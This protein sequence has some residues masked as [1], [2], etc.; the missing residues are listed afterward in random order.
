MTVE[1]IGIIT[2]L[3]G[4]I[5]LFL[6]P[7]V[8]VYIFVGSTLLGAAAAF[9]LDS[10]GG[11][12]IQPAHLLL[13]FLAFKL[14]SVRDIARSFVE[15]LFPGHAGFW[16]ALAAA[17]GTVTAYA[18][19][20]IFFAQTFVFPV[21]VQST[22]SYSTA[23]VPSTSNFTQSVYFIGNF[24]CFAL[25]Y[26]FAMFPKYRRHLARAVVLCVALNL[27]FAVADFVTYSTGTTEL[28]SI[29]RNSTY[30]LLSESEMAGFK[31]IVGSFVETSSFAYWTMG[32]FAFA[33][34]LWLYGVSPKVTSLLTIGSFIALL[35]STSTTA[36]ASLVPFGALVYCAVAIRAL[37]MPVTRQMM[38]LLTIVPIV[39]ILAVLCIA[40]N[41]DAAHYTMD[42]LDSMILNKMSTGSGMERSG[43]NSQA[44]QNFWDTFG[45]GVG[46]GS[47]RSSSFLIAALS[48]LGLIGTGIYAVFMFHIWFGQRTK[49]V[50]GSFDD[51]I[52]PAARAACLAQLIAG[53]V[54]GGL[55]DLGLPFFIFAALACIPYPAADATRPAPQAPIAFGRKPAE[56]RSTT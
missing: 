55:V 9:V 48:N 21:R 27:L 53:S 32:Y 12:T 23:L 47:A 39:F 8:L 28:M 3:A 24:A 25:L 22:G 51:A 13:G 7:Y 35:M 34:T 37:V 41:D 31:R 11:T 18:L 5:S 40:L 19:P 44:M 14:L 29:I 52:V 1:P 38:A 20:R 42:L 36:Y 33:S 2:L 45:F 4:I 10:L 16:L 6:P 15:S 46:N 49:F 56:L 30:S 26:G 17:Y 54:S 43:W 50:I